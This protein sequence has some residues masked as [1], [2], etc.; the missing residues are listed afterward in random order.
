MPTNGNK[1]QKITNNCKSSEIIKYGEKKTTIDKNVKQC[2]QMP[3][4]GQ[5]RQKNGEIKKKK[6]AS[7]FWLETT[8]NN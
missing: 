2:K 8:S 5:K 1:C 3:N 4:K 7:F 6:I